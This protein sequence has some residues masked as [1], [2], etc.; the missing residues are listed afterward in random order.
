M[1]TR[2][3]A[4]LTVLA[5]LAATAAW[6]ATAA[7]ADPAAQPGIDNFGDLLFLLVTE[8]YLADAEVVAGAPFS[9]DMRDLIGRSIPAHGPLLR[10]ERFDAIWTVGGQVGR[11]DLRRA[12]R[13]SASPDAW[14]TFVGSSRAEQ[15]EILRDATGE[16]LL[17]SPYIPLPFAFPRNAGAVTV[18][19][20]VGIAGLRSVESPRREAVVGALRGANA[21]VVRDRGSSRLLTEL[22]VEHRLA[23]DAVHALGVLH[24][25]EREPGAQV[26]IVQIS[27]SRLPALG[28]DAVGAAVAASPQLARRPIRLM[29]AGTATG[30]D[31]LVFVEHL[32]R[33]VVGV[34]GFF[35][36]TSDRDPVT[37]D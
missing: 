16:A 37:T 36:W 21:V 29:L 27:K 26:A 8:R 28:H 22:G 35:A 34:D 18:L 33:H 7:Q 4:V 11:V 9:A 2:L 10:A 31:A 25:H 19:N 32:A 17:P 6:S 20:S 1:R 24:P 3:A 30:H 15:A 12:Y 5:L 13:M 23:P 14:R